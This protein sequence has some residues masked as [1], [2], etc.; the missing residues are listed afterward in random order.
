M[1]IKKDSHLVEPLDPDVDAKSQKTPKKKQTGSEQ[2][3]RKRPRFESNSKDG[4]EGNLPSI[5]ETSRKGKGKVIES[6]HRPDV[7]TNVNIPAEDRRMVKIGMTANCLEMDPPLSTPTRQTS[8]RGSNHILVGD[9][10][11]EAPP[12][13]SKVS[14]YRILEESVSQ[15]TTVLSNIIERHTRKNQRLA[16]LEEDL[17]YAKLE[18]EKL[19]ATIEALEKEKS[20]MNARVAL[21]ERKDLY[22][23]LEAKMEGF[24]IA[25]H[26]RTIGG[27]E[28][29]NLTITKK[30]VEFP[31]LNLEEFEK[32][33][34]N[35]PN[36]VRGHHTLQDEVD[37]MGIDVCYQSLLDALKAVVGT[38][39]N[40]LVVFEYMRSIFDFYVNIN[41]DPNVQLLVKGLDGDDF[42][43]DKF[44][45][46]Q[47]P[48]S[49]DDVQA[50]PDFEE[51][52][53]TNEHLRLQAEV[54]NL[55]AEPQRV[56]R[57]TRICLDYEPTILP[58]VPPTDNPARPVILD[59]SVDAREDP[60][61]PPPS[62][63]V[64]VPTL[65]DLTQYA[66]SP[67]NEGLE[68]QGW[69][70]KN[71]LTKAD[72]ESAMY[73]GRYLRGDVINMYINEAFL[74]KPREQLHNRFYVNTFWFTKASEL[75]ARY[76]KTNH[77]EEAMIKIT[78]L[79]KSIC[80]K[81]HDEDMQ[82]NLL[83]WIFVPIHGTYHWSLAIIRL[84]NNDAWLAHLDSF[85]GTH[86]LEAIFH[87][88]KQVLYLIMPIDPALV[89]T[90]I[91]NVE[92]QQDGHSCGKH[93]LQM[94]VGA[95]RKESDGLD[96]C[97]RE[98]GLRYIATLDH[99]RSFDVVFGM[100]LSG[101]LAGPPM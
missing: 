34:V 20:E 95:A 61:S 83:A 53:R 25:N 62:Q 51:D 17:A 79:R 70:C 80:P 93:V 86:D 4:N 36:F 31:T 24:Q 94:L 58:D 89:M 7:D 22:D 71:D 6:S 73:K 66:S 39:P 75:V 46:L 38:L 43:V 78:R 14:S 96:R 15:M 57:S 11:K 19:K 99:V 88:L 33:P 27:F 69:P 3:S 21:M 63:I 59:L 85:Q 10:T 1:K 84:H 40:S 44:F 35:F 45:G 100:Y 18:E 92:Q 55:G 77:G 67:D 28:N 56:T 81:L 48:T 16:S 52:L 9:T 12:T 76:D 37:R 65:V 30:W 54:R 23:L 41:N 42:S 64:P 5:V 87:I 26:P 29:L 68:D 74:K 101:K 32:C 82:G 50:S 8:G 47:D 13:S 49:P 2:P 60:S 97:F 90:G 98:E 72:L 91:V